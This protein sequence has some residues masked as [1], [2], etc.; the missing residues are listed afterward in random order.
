MNRDDRHLPHETKLL[1]AAEGVLFQSGAK[2]E[3]HFDALRLLVRLP[4]S[5]TADPAWHL[6]HGA[7]EAYCGVMA[8]VN[9]PLRDE[10]KRLLKASIELTH[11]IPMGG[12]WR[13]IYTGGALRHF[14]SGA[15]Q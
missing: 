10:I 6:L 11:R 9:H 2:A 14:E 12:Q 13:P 3:A 7:A 5:R 15:G 1:L 4:L 8:V